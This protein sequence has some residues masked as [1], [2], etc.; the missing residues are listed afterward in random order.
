MTTSSP[1]TFPRNKI[2]ISI[3][4]V[5][6]DMGP[7]T[8]NF[9]S[10]LNMIIICVYRTPSSDIKILT[11]NLDVIISSLINKFKYILVV[12]DLNV[13]F[14]GNKVN[15][16]LQTVLNYFN[17]EAII[18]VPTRVTDTSKT[19]VDQIIKD[20]VITNLMSLKEDSLIIMHR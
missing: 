9:F 10:K 19:A 16:Y 20:Y 7:T 4:Y 3:G 12:G 13:D 15:G 11:D 8:I 2:S 14:L 1:D 6:C 5:Q 18:D 17:L